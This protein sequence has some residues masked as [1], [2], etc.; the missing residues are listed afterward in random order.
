MIC[1]SLFYVVTLHSIRQQTT[2]NRQ[3]KNEHESLESNESW[4]LYIFVS[5]RV[6]GYAELKVRV[7]NKKNRV[8][9]KKFV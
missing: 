3:Q 9:T 7:Q 8:Q 1:T 6:I 4:K 5:I 2:V